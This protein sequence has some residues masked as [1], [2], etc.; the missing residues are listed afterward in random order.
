M[1]DVNEFL[2]KALREQSINAKNPFEVICWYCYKNGF[3]YLK[4]EKLMRIFEE[5]PPNTLNLKMICSDFTIGARSEMRRIEDDTALFAFLSGL[6]SSD[7]RSSFS[8]TARKCFDELFDRA[9]E[10]AACL[11][12]REEEEQFAEEMRQYQEVLLNNERISE[13]EVRERIEMCIRDRLM[14]AITYK[15]P[16]CG[17]ELKFDPGKQQYLSLIHI[18]W[19]SIC[20]GGTWVSIPCERRFCAES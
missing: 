2:T 19:M 20:P 13:S 1:E 14:S 11:Y 17:G 15:C 3:S 7:N 10:L 5:T 16:N 18:S 12:N 6:K 4:Y 9:R 8:A